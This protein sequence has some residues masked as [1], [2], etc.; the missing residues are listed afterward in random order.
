MVMMEA[1][2]VED[3]ADEYHPAQYNML[4]VLNVTKTLAGCGE[5]GRTC[6]FVFVSVRVCV[7]MCQRAHVRHMNDEFYS[8]KVTSEESSISPVIV[9]HYLLQCT[10]Y[11]T[12]TKAIM[13]CYL[14]LECT[15]T[16]IVDRIHKRLKHFKGFQ[17]DS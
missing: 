3:T 17:T 11:A 10:T 1:G 4:A 8:L 2:L 6:V 9:S 13:A 15:S 16:Y 7:C 14:T 12:H 5:R